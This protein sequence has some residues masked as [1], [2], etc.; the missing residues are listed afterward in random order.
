[1]AARKPRPRAAAPRPIVDEPGSP[2]L[3][4]LFADLH[5]RARDLELYLIL[6]YQARVYRG[7]SLVNGKLEEVTSRRTSGLG[8]Q[9][10]SRDGRSAFAA[11][12]RLDPLEARRTLVALAA[13]VREASRRKLGANREIFKLKPERLEARPATRYDMAAVSLAEVERGARGPHDELRA[14][15]PGLK[16]ETM[17]QAS[18]DEWVVTR[19]DGA[20]A[21]YRMPRTSLVHH[22]TLA[23]AQ[24]AALTASAAVSSPSYEVIFDGAKTAL[25]AARAQRAARLLGDLAQAPHIAAGSYPLVIDYALA[26]G[27]AHEAVGHASESDSYRTSCLAR[28]GR[29][30][31]GDRVAEPGLSVIDE[32]LLGDHAYQPISPNGV[33]RLRTAIVEHGVLHQGLSDIFTARRGGVAMSGAERAEAYSSVPVPRMSNIRIEMDNPVPVTERFEDLSPDDLRELLR[34]AGRL[35]GRK[36]AFLS[37]YRGGQVNTRRGDFVFNCAAVYTISKDAIK[38]HKPAIFSGYF[39]SALGAVKTAFGPLVLD[40]IGT[41]GKWGQKVPSS[42]GSHYF[43]YLEPRPDVILGGRIA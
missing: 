33:R 41:C 13:G 12:D 16:L 43:L 42:G 19:S 22:L 26:K 38:L 39:L 4:A 35:D 40:A 31:R 14:L 3:E 30:R 34:A 2:R 23:G 29:F 9:A 10:F 32:P 7:L 11:L 36:I 37:G 25:L 15:F 24:G 20:H 28:G 1:M 6:R 17:L 5:Q 27:L 18:D 8:M 21:A